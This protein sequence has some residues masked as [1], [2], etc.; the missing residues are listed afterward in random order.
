MQNLRAANNSEALLRLP[1]PRQQTICHIRN[2][3]SAKR[4]GPECAIVRHW[5]SSHAY[6][7]EAY[8]HDG[9]ERLS[10]IGRVSSSPRSSCSSRTGDTPACSGCS[11]TELRSLD[12]K[13]RRAPYSEPASAPPADAPQQSSPQFSMTTS[14]TA[15]RIA[16]LA[17]TRKLPASHRMCRRGRCRQAESSKTTY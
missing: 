11:P 10:E 16:V 13:C 4:A 9:G 1:A 2:S 17:F 7:W 15:Y 8:A 12:T 14:V 6:V 3:R 5:S